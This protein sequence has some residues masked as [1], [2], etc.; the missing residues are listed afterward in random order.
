MWAV[1]AAWA[2]PFSYR[3]G[4]VPNRDIVA[5]VKFQLV[6]IQQTEDEKRNRR[7]ELPPIYENNAKQ[8]EEIRQELKNK[9]FEILRTESFEKLDQKVAAEF[10]NVSRRRIRLLQHL[11]AAREPTYGVEVFCVNSVVLFVV[12]DRRNSAGEVAGREFESNEPDKLAG[13]GRRQRDES[14]G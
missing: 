3:T 1:T 7:R 14:Q 10:G 2:P 8:L 12:L 9:V 11:C 5:R 4:F 13:G 6:N